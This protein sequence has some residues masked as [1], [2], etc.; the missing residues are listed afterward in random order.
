MTGADRQPSAASAAPALPWS[1]GEAE[2]SVKS[3]GKVEAEFQ[4]LILT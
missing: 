4:N 3:S 2:I 1:I